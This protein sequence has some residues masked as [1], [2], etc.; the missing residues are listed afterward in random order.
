MNVQ[1][2][3]KR[4]SCGNEVAKKGISCYCYETYEALVAGVR[5][6]AS[7]FENFPTVTASVLGVHRA[8]IPP[9]LKASLVCK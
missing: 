4:T 1:T 6:T 9:W 5:K 2:E 8:C 3:L 7:T